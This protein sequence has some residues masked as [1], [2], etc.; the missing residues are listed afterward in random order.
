MDF[1][2]L[3]NN[4]ISNAVNYTN[5]KGQVTIG[6]D[7]NENCVVFEVEDSGIGIPKKDI[8]KIFS[9]FYR[10]DNAKKIVN[11]GTGLGLSI[12]KQIVENYDGKIEIQS[13]VNKGTK[14]LV[15]IPHFKNYELYEGIK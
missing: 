15:F 6:S 4:L 13:E 14:F 10:S 3:V 12:V 8:E 1:R 2:I 7:I 9:E 11:F 5:H